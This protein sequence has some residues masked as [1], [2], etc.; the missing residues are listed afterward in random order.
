MKKNVSRFSWK[1]CGICF[2][3][4]LLI[5]F[6]VSCFA[7]L[8]SPN[9][10]TAGE[11]TSWEY[12]SAAR[13]RVV[14]TA[15]EG[16]RTA[17]A[18]HPVRP[19][20]GDC[21]IR[22]K[23]KL[24]AQAGGALRIQT[25]DSAMRV[26]LQ[27]ETVYDTLGKEIFAG[28]PLNTIPLHTFEQEQDL[29]IIIYSPLTFSLSVFQQEKA[30]QAPIFAGLVFGIFF[31][32]AGAAFCLLCLFPLRGRI[33]QGAAAYLLSA[34]MILCG[35]LLVLEAVSAALPFSAPSF[36]FNIKIALQALILWLVPFSALL[37]RA[38]WS[39][40]LEALAAFNIL[41]AVCLLFW[42]Y[43]VFLVYLIKG[44]FILQLANL[45]AFFY[46][47]FYRRLEICSLS[48][49][50]L[51]LFF[52]MNILYWQG[53]ISQ[54]SMDYS[55]QVVTAVL[56]YTV[57]GQLLL[58]REGGVLKKGTRTA[59]IVKAPAPAMKRRGRQR[60][61]PALKQSRVTAIKAVPVLEEL[62]KPASA[63]T[64]KTLAY[65]RIKGRIKISDSIWRMIRDKCDGPYHHLFHVAEY[66]RVLCFQ[67]GFGSEKTRMISDAALL[68]DIG[69]LCIPQEIL[70]KTD[71]LTEE[72]FQ[73]IRMHHLF[74]YRLLC[75]ND[76]AFSRLAAQ[77]AREHHEHMDGSG[78]I[79]L[80][81]TEIS[82][83]ARVVSVADVF[84]ALTS[85]RGY[86]KTWTFDQAFAYV[87]EHK[88]QYFDPDVVKA[89][90]QSRAQLERIYCIY[91]GRPH[92]LAAGELG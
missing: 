13:L 75:G 53:M 59:P 25:A 45:L 46:Y 92:T 2:F 18:E 10:E 77:I 3:I 87:V 47:L 54:S 38:E 70:L 60:T 80:T 26:I 44:G 31:I 32:L 62:P 63:K 86:K 9:G 48:C 76:D 24:P 90:E 68:H 84:D 89:F 83:P 4:L 69:K 15:A 27:G 20:Q 52:L 11:I 43:D 57:C 1:M 55:L 30:V 85:P 14:E 12:V 23:G 19:E 35:L 88:G 41:Y 67:M 16:W 37:G 51:L 82:L 42:P 72:E 36:L 79:G 78:Y 91:Q 65:T 73:E 58:L 61:E 29:E 34:I 40:S 50:S 8:F 81:G 33:P 7:F 17:D 64:D 22:L 56:L 74:G 5:T 6:A 49:A 28:S 66:T 21:Y 39:A 71:K